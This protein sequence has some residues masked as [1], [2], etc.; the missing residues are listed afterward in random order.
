MSVVESEQAVVC[1]R[2]MGSSELKLFRVDATVARSHRIV[3]V[4]ILISF[5]ISSHITQASAWVL[6]RH[7]KLLEL[8]STYHSNICS[9][10]IN[11][12]LLLVLLF[13]LGL[14]AQ[15]RLLPWYSTWICWATF[16]AYH[17]SICFGFIASAFTSERSEPPPI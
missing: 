5:I 14:F 2:N 15:L 3:G 13:T 12:P 6:Y 9:G 1:G 10:F 8:L 17:S 11:Q 7:L 4:E 16:V